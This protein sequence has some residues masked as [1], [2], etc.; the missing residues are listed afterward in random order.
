MKFRSQIVDLTTRGYPVG[1]DIHTQALSF[2]WLVSKEEVRE[3]C[4][5]WPERKHTSMRA[6]WE[7]PTGAD[8]GLWPTATRNMETSVLQMQ[9]NEFFQQP[10]SLEKYS[11][12]R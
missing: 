2:V 3:M 11:E 6:T 4:L 5:T 1:F 10:V 12:P 7:L 9:G 8:S